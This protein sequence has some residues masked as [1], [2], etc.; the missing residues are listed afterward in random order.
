MEM[1]FLAH[2]KNPLIFQMELDL[3]FYFDTRIT[4][5]QYKNGMART[6]KV[7]CSKN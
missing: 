6:L 3:T 1:H 4:T 7:I 5:N 2:L